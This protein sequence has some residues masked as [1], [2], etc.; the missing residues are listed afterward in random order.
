MLSYETVESHTLELL[1]RI[2]GEPTC[3]VINL[4]NHRLFISFRNSTV[5]GQPEASTQ[6]IGTQGC[7]FLMRDIV[8][9]LGGWEDAA[10]EEAA[11]LLR[12]LYLLTVVGD[13]HRVPTSWTEAHERTHSP[14]GKYL[15][16]KSRLDRILN[17]TQVSR[18]TY[19]RILM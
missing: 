9:N 1:K 8:G 19:I 17:M 4:Q 2:M 11:A 16:R 15:V 14:S 7:G 13:C 6:H 5:M 3:F 10:S 12:P 18:R